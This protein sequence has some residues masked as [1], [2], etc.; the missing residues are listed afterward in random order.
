MKR[1]L[2]WAGI[3][4]AVLFV[5]VLA[6]PFFV[7]VNDFRPT[8]ESRLTAALGREV[9]LGKLQL[10]LLS[11]EVMADDLSVAED[12]NFGTPAFLKASS[13]HV[14]V[15]LWPFL[16]SRKVIVTDL[17]IDQPQISLVHADKP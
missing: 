7:N 10:K 9:K 12:P 14:G 6:I 17:T 11:G 1:I 4:V 15:E 13:L 2:K 8:L 3:V 5:A 16:L